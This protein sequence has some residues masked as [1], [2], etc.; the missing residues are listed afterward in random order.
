MQIAGL[1]RMA[2]RVRSC[3]GG[4]R[5]EATAPAGCGVG[6]EGNAYLTTI[7]GVSRKGRS[8][9]CPRCG[10]WHLEPWWEEATQQA[11]PDSW[12]CSR[13]DFETRVAPEQE[14]QVPR[15]TH[16]EPDERGNLRG[17]D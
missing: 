3:S 2:V 12:R 1:V 11:P 15:V 5:A 16:V 6:A 7:F 17:P 10:E 8:M 4:I 9:R 14:P 13:C